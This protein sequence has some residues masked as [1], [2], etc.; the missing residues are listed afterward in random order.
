MTYSPLSPAPAAAAPGTAST[1][2][3]CELFSFATSQLTWEHVRDLLPA[4]QPGETWTAATLG[5]LALSFYAK[6]DDYSSLS[7]WTDRDSSPELF[8]AQD[9][10]D[11]WHLG[12][13]CQVTCSGI[14]LGHESLWA[15]VLNMTDH[16]TE[17]DSYSYFLDVLQQLT[18]EV[19]YGLPCS[20]DTTFSVLQ[21]ASAIVLG[22]DEPAQRSLGF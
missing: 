9:R 5:P 17:R 20:L 10:G 11:L 2:D 15:C 3:P 13:C 18:R 7:D 19:C 4:D 1:W 22:L 12:L 16:T 6:S 8:A 21:S 14:L